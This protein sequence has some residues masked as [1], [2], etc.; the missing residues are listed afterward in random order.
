M[1][2]FYAL[3]LLFGPC[4]LSEFTLA[5]PQYG[6]KISTLPSCL[7]DFMPFFTIL[8]RVWSSSL[9]GPKNINSWK[10]TQ[11]LNQQYKLERGCIPEDIK[12]FLFGIWPIRSSEE[13][14]SFFFS[15]LRSISACPVKITV[16]N[17]LSSTYNH[18]QIVETL[19]SNKVTSENRGIHT[20]P[21][22][23]AFNVRVFV[24]F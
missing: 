7:P 21:L 16:S 17:E 8:W 11:T 20:P 4:R 19:Y 18:R 2:S 12:L 6:E 24:V 23:P 15:F 22:S 3:S 10:T 13:H 1:I 9:K 14:Y 5:G